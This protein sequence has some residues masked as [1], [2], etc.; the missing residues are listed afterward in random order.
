MEIVTQMS[1]LIEELD[2][3]VRERKRLAARLEE[4]AITDGLTGLYNRRQ[5]DDVLAREW[6][7]WRRY[8]CDFSL[9]LLDIDH[10]KKINDEH[11]HQLGDEVLRVLASDLR[12]ALRRED[13]LA[14]YG[15][16]EFAVLALG[17]GAL[18]ATELAQR[19]LVAVRR[20]ATPD[21]LEGITVSI[22]VAMTD[23]SMGSEE[24]L[25]RAADDALYRAKREG[26]NRVVVHSAPVASAAGTSSANGLE[27]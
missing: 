4:L 3:E 15:G 24:D 5:F 20:M 26:R 16:E 12:G 27:R 17:T 23:P 21:P 18:A 14:R 11:G 8:G 13:C 19:L 2:L 22:G 25:I 10:F 6:A 9:L 1:V 7:R